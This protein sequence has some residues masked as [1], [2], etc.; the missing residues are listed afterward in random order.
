L[1]RQGLLAANHEPLKGEEGPAQA[2]DHGAGSERSSW[3]TG[4]RQTVG[5]QRQ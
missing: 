2:D 1:Q 3:A 5:P 4:A